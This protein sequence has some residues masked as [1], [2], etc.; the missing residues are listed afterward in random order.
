MRESKVEDVAELGK[1]NESFEFEQLPVLALV[2]STGK[3]E[4]LESCIL[5]FNLKALTLNFVR[6]CVKLT[7]GKSEKKKSCTSLP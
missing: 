6:C 5:P 2:P 4:N 1:L 7:K 3:F